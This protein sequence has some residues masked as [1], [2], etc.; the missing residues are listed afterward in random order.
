[1]AFKGEAA[2][3]TESDALVAYARQCDYFPPAISDRPVQPV[4]PA[5]RKN[6][7]ELIV[8]EIVPRLKTLHHNLTP[9]EPRPA[10]GALE[11]AE[12][13]ALA[14]G[15]DAASVSAYFEK[16]R[17][18][19]HSLDS[20]FLDLLAPTARRLGELW[21]EDACDFIDVTLGLARLQEVLR[22]F[23]CAEAQS[24]GERRQRALL[25]TAPK[26]AHGFGLEIVASFM[27]AADW[28]VTVLKGVSIEESI[29]AV[30]RESYAVFGIALAAE[31]GLETV[32]QMIYAARRAS[33]NR[34]IA[35][36]VGGRVFTSNPQLAIQVG[37]DATAPDAP[38]TTLLAKK[39]LMQ[40]I[41]T[42][43]A[44]AGSDSA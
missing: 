11:I 34:F 20:L 23:G 21:E 28:E 24:S 40:Q 30:T 31:A 5:G 26:E 42:G 41:A 14:M 18:L 25:T 8:A 6:L 10:I 2:I 16:M 19:G 37:A 44:S 4:L 9:A 1:M 27:R 35:V 3:V 17:V 39:L 22:I 12:F 32:A 43:A 36:M 38:T 7:T 15:N 13:G 29:E 33:R